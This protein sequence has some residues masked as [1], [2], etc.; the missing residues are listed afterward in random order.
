MNNRITVKLIIL[1]FL[2]V[3]LIFP[4]A[5]SLDI[6]TKDELILSQVLQKKFS[7]SD[8][9]EFAVDGG[10]AADNGFTIIN[11]NN[12]SPWKF[13]SIFRNEN[14]IKK[15]LKEKAKNIDININESDI[16]LL[17]SALIERNKKS[18]KLPLK[19]SPENGYI[20]DYNRKF[21]K[22]FTDEGIDGWEKLYRENPKAR[23]MV[24]ISLPAYNKKSNLVLVY[25]GIQFHE[26]Y[27]YGFLIL[28]S[29]N[30]NKLKELVRQ[31]IWFS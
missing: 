25:I 27:G 5:F 26:L 24:E 6:K 13:I 8:N 15:S 17:L 22:Y 18:I 23:G 10:F 12:K 21:D 29:F 7:F 11:P 20:V 4:Q 28:Y 19:L 30:D 2:A 31:R 16:N 9:G 1:S 3:Q 14:I